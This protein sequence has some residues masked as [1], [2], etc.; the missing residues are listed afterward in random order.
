M[1]G[2]IQF[3]GVWNGGYYLWYFRH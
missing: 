2:T 1:I 3:M